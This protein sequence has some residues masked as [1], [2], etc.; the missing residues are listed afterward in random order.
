[1]LHAGIRD[2]VTEQVV[3][4]LCGLKE[5]GYRQRTATAGIGYLLP[6]SSWR[7]QE[8]MPG[9]AGELARQ[10]ASLVHRY[11]EPTCSGC[12]PIT[13]NC[14]L[15]PGTPR[16]A[17]MQWEPAE[18]PCCSPDTKDASRQSHFSASEWTG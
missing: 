1:M 18:S 14:S 11:A 12:R 2:E 7:E 10:P 15:R 4:Q 9:N 6:D 13:P 3:S 8:I 5:E 17:R 16:P